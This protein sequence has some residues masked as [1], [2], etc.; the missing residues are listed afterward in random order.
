LATPEGAKLKGTWKGELE[1][2]VTDFTSGIAAPTTIGDAKVRVSNG[3]ITVDSPTSTEVN[4]YA[5]NGAVVG[6]ANGIHVEINTLS[7]G[8]YFV[9]CGGKTHKVQVK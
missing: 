7:K 9:S 2:Y 4:V 5:T 8:L 1:K 3:I 6:H